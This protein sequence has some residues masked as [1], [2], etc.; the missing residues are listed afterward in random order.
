MFAWVWFVCELTV[1]LCH[2]ILIVY[3]CLQGSNK[4]GQLGLGT[5]SESCPR[6]SRVSLPSCVDLA[7]CFITGGGNHTVLIDANRKLHT[8]GLI[9]GDLRPTFVADERFPGVQFVSAACGW[10]FSLGLSVE[11]F[12]YLWGSSQ[13]VKPYQALNGLRIKQVSAG[14]R[15][16][17]AITKEGQLHAWGTDRYTVSQDCSNNNGK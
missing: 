13:Y 8:A 10:D 7:N 15:F 3:L 16:A 2:M 4:N 1:S 14:M 12:V 11:G 5:I 17:A 9:D 6:P